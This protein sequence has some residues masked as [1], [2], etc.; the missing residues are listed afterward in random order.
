MSVLAQLTYPDGGAGAGRQIAE[1]G[2][3]LD[4][5]QLVRR[6]SDEGVL[7]LFYYYIHR[8]HLRDLLPRDLV[9]LLSGQYHA[10]LKRNMV[11]CAILQPLFESFNAQG[12]PFIVLKGISLAELVYPGFGIRGMSDVDLL[13]KKG[14]MPRVD[15]CLSA[16]GYS[17]RDSSVAEALHNPVGYLASLDYRK[18]DGSFPN[19]HIHWHPVNTSV[20]ATM[21]AGRIDLDRLW[22][23]AV[24][25]T[26]A[27]TAV[28]ILCPEHQLLYLCEHALRINHSFDRLILMYDILFAVRAYEQ[29]ID[30]DYVVAEAARFNIT[31]LV[32]LS[33]SIVR[34][35][36]SLSLSDALMER[37]S[38]GKL[39][40]G[41]KLFLT[42]QTG[43]R[44]FRGGSIFVY[45]G[46]NDG[47][48][49][50]CSFLYRTFFPPRQIL[51][52]RR[53]ANHTPFKPSF[54]A[55]RVW[56]VLSQLVRV[57]R[58]NR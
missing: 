18:Q 30:W 53:Y 35:H 11:A 44:R 5:N 38:P 9:T 31:T 43:N 40:C 27:N 29:E 46:M 34:R 23:R 21:F 12:L 54:Y 28:R 50:K 10:N 22:L 57:S 6:M 13:V 14:D 16:L 24:P 4:W 56:E 51:M 42:L 1:Q 41:D 37:L 45:L 2:G 3:S 36:T 55:E 8:F 47:F 17:S 52:Q 20:P 32:F 25:A 26:V 48:V 58:R 39:K 15:A 19:I 49:E 33:L 7:C